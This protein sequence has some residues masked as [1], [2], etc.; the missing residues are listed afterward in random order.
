MKVG[1][2]YCEEESPFSSGQNIVKSAVENGGIEKIGLIIAFSHGYDDMQ[3]FLDGIR[4]V[5][6]EKVSVIGG[7]AS[8]IISNDIICYN[9]KAALAA[10]IETENSFGFRLSDGVNPDGDELAGAVRFAEKLDREKADQLLILFFNL[11]K[12]MPLDRG[13]I[14]LVSPS[15]VLDKIEQVIGKDIPIIGAGLI[16]DLT[17]TPSILFCG[18]H[19]IEQ[20]IIGLMLTGKIKPYIQV[21]HGQIPLDGIYYRVTRVDG[22]YLYELDGNPV[23]ELIDEL[24]GSSDWRDQK[25]IRMLSIGSNYGKR[26]GK[27]PEA[28]YVSRV[29][30]GVT[31]DGEGITLTEAG[32][33]GGDEIQFMLRD[34]TRVMESTKNAVD[35]LFR[36]ISADNKRALFGL[37]LDCGGRTALHLNSTQEEA[38]E[39][40]RLFNFHGIPLIGVYSGCEI[41][42]MMDSNRALSYTGV[43]MVLAGD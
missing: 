34:V 19:I 13:S 5:A 20:G 8:G 30:L 23:P 11:L 16:G 24:Y 38:A 25:P 3:G 6:G 9:G 39:V 43:M 7:A 35:E 33:N 12:Q 10:V 42:P 36:E 29:I 4:S 1:I 26:F 27:L 37:Y 17:F 28:A 22:P 14:K 32:L 21:T 15:R 2:G 40:Q 41:A 31:P 18:N